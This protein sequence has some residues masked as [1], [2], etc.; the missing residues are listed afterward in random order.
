MHLKQRVVIKVHFV[1]LQ[2]NFEHRISS[3]EVLIQ[4]KTIRLDQTPRLQ[5]LWERLELIVGIP[6][7][8]FH[9]T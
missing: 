8:R 9:E 3:L 2:A 5:I 4:R 6:L 7:G 1:V